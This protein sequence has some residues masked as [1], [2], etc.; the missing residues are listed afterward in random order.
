MSR[1]GALLNNKI[2]ICLSLQIAFKKHFQI[3]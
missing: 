1:V 3:A 2:G